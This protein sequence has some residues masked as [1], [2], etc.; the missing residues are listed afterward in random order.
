MDS[1]ALTEAEFSKKQH[2][3]TNRQ[4]D[5]M[6]VQRAFANLKKVWPFSILIC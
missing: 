5:A 1:P 4:G 6:T 2:L 3:E